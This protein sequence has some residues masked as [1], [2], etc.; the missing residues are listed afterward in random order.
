MASNEYN[1]KP[2]GAEGQEGGLSPPPPQSFSGF[3][4]RA[5][6][7]CLFFF[8]KSPYNVSFLKEVIKNAHENQ[9]TKRVT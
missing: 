3:F 9:Y 5:L 7:M 4:R 6:K 2:S 8:S 1:C